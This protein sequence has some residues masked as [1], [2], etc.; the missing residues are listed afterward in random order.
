[1]YVFI[2]EWTPALTQALNK[3]TID[4]TNSKNPP[5][6]HGSYSW[7][8]GRK[9]KDFISCLGYIFASYMVAMMMGSN[10]FE[11]FRN[12]TTPESFTRFDWKISHNDSVQ[13]IDV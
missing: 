8:D 10:A 2:L 11:V 12:Q 7:T 9:V 6:P 13:L 5:I 3:A 4:K 1:M